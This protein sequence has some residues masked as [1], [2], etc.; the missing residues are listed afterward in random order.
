MNLKHKKMNDDN[1][2]ERNYMNC[3]LDPTESELVDRI[4]LAIRIIKINNYIMTWKVNIEQIS[5]YVNT[6]IVWSFFFILYAST[7][8][9][10][11]ADH[12]EKI[13]RMSKRMPNVLV[14]L[15]YETNSKVF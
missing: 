15:K 7:Q 9:S 5:D 14:L 1:S 3:K 13:E 10:G 11:R 4:S 6:R 2:N 8:S 12:P